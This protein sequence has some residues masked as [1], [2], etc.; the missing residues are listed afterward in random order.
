MINQNWAL[1]APEIVLSLCAMAILV[2]GVLWEE[3]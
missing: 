3:G 2:F 1:A